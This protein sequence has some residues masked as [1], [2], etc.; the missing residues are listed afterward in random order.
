MDIAI[1][2]TKGQLDGLM[3]FGCLSLGVSLLVV[4]ARWFGETL[5]RWEDMG[6][7]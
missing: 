3:V 6:R 1:H 2:V 4:L 5:V 7:H